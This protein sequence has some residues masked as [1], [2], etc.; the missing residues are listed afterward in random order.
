MTT[1][2]MTIRLDKKEK[3]LISNYAAAFGTSVSEFMRKA[4]LERI[5][6][7][8]DLKAWE[9]AKAEFDADPVTISAAEMA[10]KYL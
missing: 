2:T 3:A 8:L 1:A 6:D 5:E 9:E 10:K 7:E 4:A